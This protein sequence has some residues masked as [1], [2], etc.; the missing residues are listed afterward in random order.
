[1][2]EL[3]RAQLQVVP[4]VPQAPQAVPRA[5]QAVLQPEEK[6][7]AVAEPGPPLPRGIP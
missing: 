5:P 7:A 3:A 2:R 6:P 4:R 1:M